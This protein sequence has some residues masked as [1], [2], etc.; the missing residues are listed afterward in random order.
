MAG[1]DLSSE[2]SLSS[3][4]ETAANGLSIFWLASVWSMAALVARCSAVMLG[5]RQLQTSLVCQYTM[6]YV[7]A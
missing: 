4:E 6:K 3:L 1:A 5:D 2:S 7:V